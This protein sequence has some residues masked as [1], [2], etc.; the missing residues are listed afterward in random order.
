MILRP[1]VLLGLLGCQPEHPP[2]FPTALDLLETVDDSVTWDP[3]PPPADLGSHAA[4]LV[5]CG[6]MRGR[7]EY[8]PEKD[9][10]H[11]WHGIDSRYR[12]DHDLFDVEDDQ[13]D[14]L[15]EQQPIADITECDAE[16]AISDPMF[17]ISPDLTWYDSGAMVMTSHGWTYNL[18]PSA[19]TPGLYIGNI[20]I[21]DPD[22]A[23]EA[24]VRRVLGIEYPVVISLRFM[25]ITTD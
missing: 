24:A 1:I 13:G 5:D 23:C 19:S 4:F 15:Y 9:P 22:G 11:R 20:S 2:P 3:S 21:P 25:G 10:G 17:E 8:Y 14:P 16:H 18:V 6:F 12:P 7:F